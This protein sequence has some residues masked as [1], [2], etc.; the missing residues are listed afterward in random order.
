MILTSQGRSAWGGPN[1]ALSALKGSGQ[2]PLS[3]KMTR[4]EDRSMFFVVQR[5]LTALQNQL[6]PA[7]APDPL[8]KTG[9]GGMRVVDVWNIHNNDSRSI[10]RIPRIFGLIT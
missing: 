10:P 2:P 8:K 1:H 5:E 9:R 3:V 6:T 7:P 4:S